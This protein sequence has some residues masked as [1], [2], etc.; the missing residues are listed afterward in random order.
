MI[1]PTLPVE[2]GPVVHLQV[3]VGDMK[4]P[5]VARS[6]RAGVH[7]DA[8]AEHLGPWEAVDRDPLLVGDEGDPGVGLH[9][10]VRLLAEP[11]GLVD[12]ALEVGRCHRG[13]HLLDE[14][15]GGGGPAGGLGVGGGRDDE[16]GGEGERD[17]QHNCSL[18][19]Q[20]RAFAGRI[21][22]TQRDNSIS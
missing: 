19:T 5:S 2:S 20:L 1:R 17:A 18:C 10:P 13:A 6:I 12:G 15:G 16:D 9:L 11:L 7:H 14:D 4:R 3:P 22:P 8:R 21:S